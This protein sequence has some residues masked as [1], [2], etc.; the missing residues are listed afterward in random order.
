M[1]SASGC[2]ELVIAVGPVYAASKAAEKER[3]L[4]S[5][6]ETSLAVAAENGC[7]S[8]VRASSHGAAAATLLTSTSQ[9]FSA[10]SCGIYGYPLQDASNVA[11]ETT[12]KFL[13]GSQGD[14]V[15][16]TA[17]DFRDAAAT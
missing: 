5:C 8:V 4:R 3:Q 12:R 6:Y 1:H 15:R 11:L 7:K 14:Q 10:I 16:P 13:E 9:A 2:A 17:A